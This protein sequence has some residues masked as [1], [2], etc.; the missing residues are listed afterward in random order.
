MPRK[1]TTNEA[2]SGAKK[3]AM[4]AAIKPMLATLV[5]KP[6]SDPGW[7]FETKWDGVRAICFIQNGNARFVSR[8]QLEMTAQYP[9]LTGIAASVRATNLILD[10]EI[11]ALDEHGVSRFQLLQRRLGRKNAG[12]I[13]RLASTTRLAYY[14]FD[15][16]YIDGFDLMSCTLSDRK[17]TLETILKSSK[18]V[19]YSDHIMGEGEKLYEAIAKI[20]LEGIIAKR[21]DSTYVQKR[22]ADWLKIKTTLESEVV[23]A[24]YT[25]PRNSRSYFGALV[26]GLYEEGELH[27]VGHTGGGFNQKTLEH[28]YKLMQPLKTSK[29]PF[30]EKIKTNEPVQ[31]IKPKLVAQV[32]FSEWTA[33]RRM[34]HPIFL[35]MRTDKKAS[36]CTFEIKQSTK[37]VV[38]RATARRKM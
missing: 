19:L 34:R 20:P 32:K 27:Y 37:K 9:E 13:G 28:V 36:E 25:Q 15:V 29:S 4:P 16:L 31:W 7:L 38:S 35:G 8:N 6:F 11:V 3:A 23:V 21:L 26:V 12:E 33:D 10:G 22:S 30:V 14:V 2:C 5:D 17:A 1:K 24:G 18:N